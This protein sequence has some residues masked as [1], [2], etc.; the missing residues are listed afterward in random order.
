EGWKRIQ[1]AGRRHALESGLDEEIRFHIDQQT[2]KN[3]RAGMSPDEAKRQALVKFGGL[4]RVKESTRDEIRSALLEDSVRDLRHGIRVLRR[5]PAFTAAALVTLALGIGATSAIFSVVRTVMLEP[6]PYHEPDRIVAVWETSRGGASR[7]VIAPAN[8]VAWRERTRTLEHLGMVEPAS[9][10]MIVNG[11]PDNIRGLTVS[12]EVFRA[13]GVQPAL[14]RAYTAEEDPGK[15]VIVL[16]HEFW[17]RR[18]GG[19]RDVLDIT[20]ATDDGPRTVIGVMPARFTMVG[21]KADFLIPYGQTME[22]LR[23]VRGRGSSYAIARLREGVSLERAYTEMRRI[24]AELENEE[25]QRN[26]R[27]T[28]MLLPLQEQMVG[29]IRPALPRGLRQRRES[30]AGAERRARARARHAFGAWRKTGPP[31]APDAHRKSGTRGR[32]RHRGVGRRRPVSS[33]SARAGG[34]SHPGS[35]ARPAGARSA[36]GGVHDSHRA[37]D[38]HRL[39]CRSGTGLDEP[40]KR[41]AARR[42]TSRRRPPVAPGAPRARRRRGCAVARAAC[43]RRSVDA[44]LRQAAERRPGLPY[45][46]RAHGGR[47]AS[48]HAIRLPPGRQRLPRISVA[49]CRAARGSARGRG[50]LPA[51]SIPVHRHELLARGSAKAGGWPVV[52]RPGAADHAG[53]LQDDGHSTTG[54]T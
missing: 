42:R 30:A 32:R 50:L 27:R 14:G 43:W 25:P 41:R 35:A 10:A 17:Q 8:F 49:H 46:R 22:Q 37:G 45:G 3:R 51:G 23:A 19:R 53:I 28:V 39:R 26:A 9:L 7:N 40:R 38:R 16:S 44:Q 20:F 1:S 48:N 33:R 4:E 21:Q 13:L 5:A 15:A 24:F 18:L 31:R 34:R 29:E 47:A 6:L 52:L 54:G 36:G 2:E 12:S 11:Q